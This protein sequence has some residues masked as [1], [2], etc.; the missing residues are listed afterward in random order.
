MISLRLVCAQP[1]AGVT[2]TPRP[3]SSAPAGVPVVGD[4]VEVGD[5]VA[6]GLGAVEAVALGTGVGAEVEVT[7]GDGVGAGS[8][9]PPN[10]IINSQPARPTATRA[11]TTTPMIMPLPLGLGGGG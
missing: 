3:T 1:S 4:A 2:L 5:A 7:V 10:R 11:A 9:P 8:L 6:L